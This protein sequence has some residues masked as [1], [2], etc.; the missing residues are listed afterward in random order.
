MYDKTIKWES[1]NKKSG[2]REAKPYLGE[3]I[4]SMRK[5]L[6]KAGGHVKL[7]ATHARIGKEIE[8]KKLK[9]PAVS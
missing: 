5:F 2:E 7:E 6:S 3:A 1:A 4:M 8:K 9:A